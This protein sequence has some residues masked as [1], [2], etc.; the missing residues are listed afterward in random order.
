MAKKDQDQEAE[1]EPV[2]IDETT[3]SID[4]PEPDEPVDTADQAP[5]FEIVE[6]PEEA[7]EEAGLEPA[8]EGMVYVTYTGYAEALTY[9]D[10]KLTPG[11]PTLVSQE[12]AEGITTTPF[13]DFVISD[14]SVTGPPAQE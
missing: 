1:L 10:I 5:L 3:G 2:E 11:T 7:P 4:E 8:P 9:G 12:D 14:G 6:V 13:E